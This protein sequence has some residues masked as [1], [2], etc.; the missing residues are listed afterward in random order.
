MTLSASRLYLQLLLKQ[1]VKIKCTNQN[2]IDHNEIPAKHSN[3]P[4]K[5]VE[6]I[7]YKSY[8][9]WT[10]NVTTDAIVYCAKLLSWHEMKGKSFTQN[11]KRG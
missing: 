10:E 5:Q 8:N 3:F 7:I 9:L 1:G 4:V 11:K 2:S 6:S